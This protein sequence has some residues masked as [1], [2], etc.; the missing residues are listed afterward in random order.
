MTNELKIISKKFRV[1]SGQILNISDDADLTILKVFIE[2]LNNEEFL[3]EFIYRKKVSDDEMEKLIQK[4]RYMQTFDVST[5]RQQMVYEVYYILNYILKQQS[6][7]HSVIGYAT[8]SNK[9]IDSVKNFIAKTVSPFIDEIRLYIEFES[10][11]NNELNQN[12]TKI[13]L[14]YCQKDSDIAD[15]VDN[16]ITGLIDCKISRDVRDVKYGDSFNAFMKLVSEK[17]YVI[18]IISDAYLKSMNCMYEVNEA[19]RNL[20]YKKKIILIVLKNED[21]RFYSEKNLY[22][23]VPEIYDEKRVKY[24]TYWQQKSED[25]KIAR[26]QIADDLLKVDLIEDGRKIEKIKLNLNEFLETIRDYNH[27]SLTKA[28]ND[29]FEAIIN[30]IK[31]Q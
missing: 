11:H 10:A 16:K 20:D 17:D 29:N 5:D 8:N 9:L 26:S 19:M 24:I 2:F 18:M 15:E 22:D 3:K 25:N 13:F 30:F 1:Y 28:I 27:Q 7:M 23:F 4:R 6:I 31:K 21:S 14:S 12:D